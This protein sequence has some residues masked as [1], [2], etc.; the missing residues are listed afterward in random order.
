PGVRKISERS[1]PMQPHSARIGGPQ[2]AAPDFATADLCRPLSSAIDWLIRRL[3]PK[4]TREPVSHSEN[5]IQP[6]LEQQLS[7]MRQAL[8]EQT[9]LLRMVAHDLRMPLTSIQGYTELLQQGIYGPLSKEQ[10][11]VLVRIQHSTK[12]LDR[13]AGSLLD[14]MPVETHTLSLT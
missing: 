10:A 2:L 5:D 11:A 7:A 6:E 14:A 9:M 1:T 8:D 4:R 12:F 13:L 3:M